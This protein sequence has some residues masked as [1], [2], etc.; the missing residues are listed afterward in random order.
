[1]P[2]NDVEN[3]FLRS[4]RCDYCSLITRKCFQCPNCYVLH[5]NDFYCF[6]LNYDFKIVQ[7]IYNGKYVIH[8]FFDHITIKSPFF[9]PPMGDQFEIRIDMSKEFFS[10]DELCNLA[11]RVI[12]KRKKLI[13]CF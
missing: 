11:E 13:K 3:K 4:I 1:M 5:N 8:V 6:R 2:T 12:T 10:L 9:V 7:S